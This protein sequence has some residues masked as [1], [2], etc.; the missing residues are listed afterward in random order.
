MN[1]ALLELGYTNKKVATVFTDLSGFTKFSL[2]YNIE[3]ALLVL[4]PLMKEYD[5][6]IKKHN[7]ILIKSMGDSLFV[8][9]ENVKN[10]VDSV[11]EMQK[12]TNDY[13]AQESNQALFELCA[14]IGYGECYES[15]QG[16][17][18]GNEVN[19]ASKLGEDIG[20]GR[21]ILV[22]QNCYNKMIQEGIENLVTF[23]CDSLISGVQ[24]ATYK[25][26][27]SNQICQK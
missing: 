16:D 17:F 5:K 3:S 7:G 6:C 24:I 2:K 13:K 4:D 26:T 14:G 11:L 12:I 27:K 20:K 18:F 22:T 15:N 21:E 10:A 25:L 9:F 1:N 8:I 23:E 19:L